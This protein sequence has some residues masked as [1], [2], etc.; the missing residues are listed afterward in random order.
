MPVLE[1]LLANSFPDRA[2]NQSNKDQIFTPPHIAK[3]M[4]QAVVKQLPEDKWNKDLKI[5]DIYCKSGI[6]LYEFYFELFNGTRHLYIEAGLSDEEI[7][8]KCRNHILENQLYGICT[9]PFLQLMSTRTVYGYIPENSNIKYIK[10]FDSIVN[11]K[12]PKLFWETIKENFGEDKMKKFGVVIGNPPYNKGMDLDFVHKAYQL[13]DDKDGIVCMITPAKW[14]TAADDYSG[15]ASKTIDYKQFREKLV[16]H[17]SEV[18]FYF[19]CKDIF[20]IGQRDG[21]TW[22]IIDKNTHE[23]TKIIN[24]CRLQPYFNSE[25]M[26]SLREREFV[27]HRHGN[28]A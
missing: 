5:L 14:Q 26:R 8:T 13:S 21:I 20:D 19:D 7:D 22:Y 1:N 25:S 16:P 10:Y 11:N 12:D 24:K 23:K 27:K 18:C 28:C 15:C 3:E 4:V 2:K 9:D 6:F 17:M